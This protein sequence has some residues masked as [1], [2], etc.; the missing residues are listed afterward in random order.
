MQCSKW[1]SS[2][3]WA[4]LVV[5]GLQ[6]LAVAYPDQLS[7]QEWQEQVNNFHSN[8]VDIGISENMLRYTGSIFQLLNETHN[9]IHFYS[10]AHF[11]KVLEDNWDKDNFLANNLLARRRKVMSNALYKLPLTRGFATF[12]ATNKPNHS[13]HTQIIVEA[14]HPASMNLHL[15]ELKSKLANSWTK[16]SRNTIAVVLAAGLEYPLDDLPG[17]ESLPKTIQERLHA[18]PESH[19]SQGALALEL[20]RHHFSNQNIPVRDLVYDKKLTPNAA[21]K[22]YVGQPLVFATYNSVLLATPQPY[23]QEANIIMDNSLPSNYDFYHFCFDAREP[24]AS[25]FDKPSIAENL[26]ALKELIKT[27]TEYFGKDETN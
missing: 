11:F 16:A 10:K 23:C 6:R 2:L 26:E 13:I 21:L 17:M 7:K 5:S 1:L 18:S 20:F 27:D 22:S 15:V 24:T 8:L 9:N 12:R 25:D 3:L 19:I 4:L 14:S